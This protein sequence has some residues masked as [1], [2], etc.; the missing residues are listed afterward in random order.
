MKTADSDAPDEADTA[1]GIDGLMF[2]YSRWKRRSLEDIATAPLSVLAVR[3]LYLC[4]CILF[5]GV[6]L[7]WIIMIP[8]GG[9]SLPLFAVLLVPAVAAEV[10]GYRR[11]RASGHV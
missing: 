8:E 1:R 5:D 11:L 9:F 2:R 4:A 7:P 6:I 3:S 10:L